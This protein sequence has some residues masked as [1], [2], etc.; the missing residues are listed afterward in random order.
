MIV[1]DLWV[2]RL[3]CGL[4]LLLFYVELSFFLE[5]ISWVEVEQLNVISVLF[6]E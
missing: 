3:V 4:G 5:A 6:S 1:E 2:T